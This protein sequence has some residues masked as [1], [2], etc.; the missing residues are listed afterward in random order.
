MHKLPAQL[1]FKTK[2][3]S[4]GTSDAPKYFSL[5]LISA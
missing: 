1:P 2:P 4:L 5:K 3:I